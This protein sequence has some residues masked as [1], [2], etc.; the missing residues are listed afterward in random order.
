MLG[1]LPAALIAIDAVRPD[2]VSTGALLALQV[3]T[4]VLGGAGYAA[5]FGLLA[6]RLDERRGPVTR[7]VA[8]VGQRSLTFYLFN[9]VLVAVVLHHDLLAVG[10]RVDS[11][12]ALAVA[13]RRLA[14]GAGRR[15]V[16]GPH[17][18]S[19]SGGRAAAPARGRQPDG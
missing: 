10:D 15:G 13:A 2:I 6:L 12:G 5:A 9:S 4:G 3:L 17:R 7:A 1:A 8:A 11:I 14:R 18:P 19:R 16:D